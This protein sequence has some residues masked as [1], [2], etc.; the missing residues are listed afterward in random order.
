MA[1]CWIEPIWERRCAFQCPGVSEWLSALELTGQS[2]L[3]PPYFENF[4]K[5]VQVLCP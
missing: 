3:V 4:C 1:K 5:R 2:V